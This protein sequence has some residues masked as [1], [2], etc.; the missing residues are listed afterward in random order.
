MALGKATAGKGG[1]TTERAPAGNHPAVLVAIIDLGEQWNDGYQGAPGSWQHRA[2]FVWE[3]VTKKQTGFK[4][5][6]HVIAIDLT[7]SMNEKAKLRLWIEARTGRKIPDGESF[8]I[9]TE[10]GKECLLN[11]VMNGDYPKIAGL[12]AIP[13]GFT[14]PPA[15]LKPVAWELD[16]KN[17]GAI[18]EWCPWLYGT[19]IP[20][21]VRQSKELGGK[22]GP[23]TQS[24]PTNHA[25]NPGTVPQTTGNAGDVP[26]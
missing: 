11:V 16:E 20:D 18:P 6:N 10:L 5:R 25:S 22:A 2:Y 21:V 12:S 1:G 13:E 8:D 3:L 9:L 19:S 7:W 4:D 17:L 15:L 23:R 14:I 24:Q 26:Y